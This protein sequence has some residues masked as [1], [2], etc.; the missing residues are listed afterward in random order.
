[1]LSSGGIGSNSPTNGSAARAVGLPALPWK[2]LQNVAGM[3]LTRVPEVGNAIAQIVEMVCRSYD[4]IRERMGEAMA[5]SLQGAECPHQLLS[6]LKENVD[7]LTA[8]AEYISHTAA[9]ELMSQTD[10]HGPNAKTTTEATSSIVHAF[11]KLHCTFSN[12]EVA[13]KCSC[14]DQRPGVLDRFQKTCAISSAGMAR[15]FTSNMQLAS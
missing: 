8:M 6:D 3:M 4:K 2:R 15:L 1:M 11:T 5:P 12:T 9:L 13:F 7:T 14:T 10:A